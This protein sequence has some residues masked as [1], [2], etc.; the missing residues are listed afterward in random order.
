MFGLLVLN[1]VFE[2]Q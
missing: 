2:C 1:L